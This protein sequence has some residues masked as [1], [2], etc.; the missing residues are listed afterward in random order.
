V[1]GAWPLYCLNTLTWTFALGAVKQADNVD[2][3]NA[4]KETAAMV[5]IPIRFFL[6]LRSMVPSLSVNKKPNQQNINLPGN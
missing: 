1:R 3:N 4:T 5:A 6:L 2:P